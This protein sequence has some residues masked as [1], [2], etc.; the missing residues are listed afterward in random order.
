MIDYRRAL[1][2]LLAQ[3]RPV[4]AESVPLADAVGRV[5]AGDIHSPM[6]LP[7][8]DNAAMDGFA[9]AARGGVLPHDAAYD[10]QASQ[11]AGDAQTTA[12]ANT[13]WEIMTGARVPDGL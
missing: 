4:E 5:L 1:A 9:L 3:S 13:A 10:V 7:G 2:A 8:F 12:S 11:A 6:H